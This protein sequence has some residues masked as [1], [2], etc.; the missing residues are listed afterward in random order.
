MQRALL[1]KP[2]MEQQSSTFQPAPSAA[3]AM[4][5]AYASFW[6]R[7]HAYSIDSI[8]TTLLYFLISSF[9]GGFAFAQSPADTQIQALIAA[10][11]LPPDTAA[12][13]IHEALR[14][15]LF[16]RLSFADVGLPLLFSA[17]YNTVFVASNW[18]AT[19]GKRLF[20]AYVVNADGSPL[21][22]QQAALRH[23]ASGASTLLSGLP[24]LM[25]FFTREKLAP[26]DMLC[27]TRVIIGKITA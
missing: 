5:V 6:R 10:G 25:I 9:L 7:L 21:T 26:H 17:L 15:A 14:M 2:F 1:Y 23:L 24:Y 8:L 13:A 18:Q 27:Q 22:H 19:P 20:K 16:D 4:P 3:Q 12:H 11:I